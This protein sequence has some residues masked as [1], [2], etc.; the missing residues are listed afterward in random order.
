MEIT[1][2]G[3]N[4][5]STFR[6]FTTTNLGTAPQFYVDQSETE[7][8]VVRFEDHPSGQINRFILDSIKYGSDD[9]AA[10]SYFEM[11]VILGN[12]KPLYQNDVFKMNMGSAATAVASAPVWCQI[13]N[14]QG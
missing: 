10:L 4:V 13:L 12:S 7:A 5:Q 3:A 14:P 11:G 1:Y 6:I 2:S 8:F 9:D